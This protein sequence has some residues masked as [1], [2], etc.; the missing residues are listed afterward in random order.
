MLTLTRSG[1]NSSDWE[2]ASMDSLQIEQPAGAEMKH[3]GLGV[4][5]FTLAM[6]VLVLTF[7][8]VIV[9]GVMETSAPAGMDEG[10]STV[11]MLGF[12]I[13]GMLIANVVAFGLGIG[14]IFQ[15][16]RKKLYAVLGMTF[17][18]LTFIGTIGLI[19]V[20]LSMEGGG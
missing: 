7:I 6:V 20:G 11:I 17:A 9:A 5:S 19:L 2:L 4:A 16:N 10:S 15:Q 8:I 12:A 13:I 3:S 18:M 14:G 1:T